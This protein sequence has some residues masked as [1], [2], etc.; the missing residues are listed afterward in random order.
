[1][2]EFH[3]GFHKTATT[4]IQ[5]IYRQRQASNAIVHIHPESEVYQP[6]RA[7]LLQLR[8]GGGD[9]QAAER[10]WAKMKSLLPSDITLRISDENVIG[11]TP[12]GPGST[13]GSYCYPMLERQISN[14]ENIFGSTIHFIA[15]CRNASSFIYS[16]YCDG[17]RYGR[18]SYTF[19]EYV[20]R[21]EISTFDNLALIRRIA[22]TTNSALTAVNYDAFKA[23]PELFLT[24][25]ISELPESDCQ[26]Y[27]KKRINTSNTKSMLTISRLFGG[28]SFDDRQKLRQ[29]LN[30]IPVRLRDNEKT[31]L[32][33]GADDTVLEHIRKAVPSDTAALFGDRVSIRIQ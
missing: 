14:L 20:S 31:F 3:I 27:A 5:R 18:Y 1:M 32:D 17:L 2:I 4:L 30:Q 24:S 6:L 23:N 11:Q 9:L 25:F 16:M 8:N 29:W 33:V 10:A 19:H 13:T 26:S 15:S 21:L 22:S 7:E 12:F 28:H